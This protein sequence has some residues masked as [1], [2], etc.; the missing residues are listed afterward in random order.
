MSFQ[1]KKAIPISFPGIDTGS[2]INHH[3]ANTYQNNCGGK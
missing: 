2:A 1:E 3:Y